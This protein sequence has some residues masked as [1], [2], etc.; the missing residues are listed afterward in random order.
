MSFCFKTIVLHWTTDVWQTQCHYSRVQNWQLNCKRKQNLSSLRKAL[1]FL[2]RRDETNLLED[3][4]L[5]IT[6]QLTTTLLELPAILGHPRRCLSAEAPKEQRQGQVTQVQTNT[7]SDAPL[8]NFSPGQ[9]WEHHIGLLWNLSAQA[10]LTSLALYDLVPSFRQPVL[11][12]RRAAESQHLH[13]DSPTVPFQV[14][15]RNQWRCKSLGRFPWGRVWRW[16]QRWLPSRRGSVT[17]PCFMQRPCGPCML[18]T[19][20]PES[21]LCLGRE[22]IPLQT[23]VT[24]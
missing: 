11:S 22:V 14:A 16:R 4:Y 2:N 19:E 15:R 6:F 17:R 13:R 7:S 12:Q 24:N 18:S 21:R 5:C 20:P 1:F 8:R 10:C 3:K 9:S 23:H